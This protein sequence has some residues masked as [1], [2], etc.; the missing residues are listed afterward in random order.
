MLNYFEL[1]YFTD[2]SLPKLGMKPLV[3]QIVMIG[4]KALNRKIRMADQYSSG[5]NCQKNSSEL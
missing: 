4:K 2:I 5:Y 1:E 3:A